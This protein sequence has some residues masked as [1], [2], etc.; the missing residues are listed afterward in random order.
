M[1]EIGH[2]NII[3]LCAFFS[4]P[5][6]RLMIGDGHKVCKNHEAVGTG[7]DDLFF[8]LIFLALSSISLIRFFTK[9]IDLLKLASLFLLKS[10]LRMLAI[11]AS[12]FYSISTGLIIRLISYWEEKD[13]EEESLD[14]LCEDSS[15]CF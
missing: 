6:S 9:Q 8:T 5:T 13:A 11:F 4:S 2:Y 12:F 7:I 3:K 15:L 14:L 1:F 10:M